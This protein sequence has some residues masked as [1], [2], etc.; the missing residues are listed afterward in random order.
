MNLELTSNFDHKLNIQI[1]I[2]NFY[3]FA[4]AWIEV[5]N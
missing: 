4:W 5:I 3:L 2:S 1:L